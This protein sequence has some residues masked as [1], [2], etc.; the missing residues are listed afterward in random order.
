MDR[1]IVPV[2][3]DFGNKWLKLCIAING[4]LR[5]TNLPAAYA[6]QRPS[7][8]ILPSSGKEV[9]RLQ[10]FSLPVGDT[11]LW[12]GVDI[13][14]GP[15]FQK[16]DDTKYDPKHISILFKAGL[17]AWSQKHKVDLA[18]L[19]KLNVVASMPPGAFADGKSRK[20]A[21]AAYRKAFNRGKSHLQIDGAQVVTQF[22]GLQREAVG[23]IGS[24]VRAKTTT[25]IVDIGS[26]TVDYV[27]YN[28]GLSPIW[29]KSANVGLA[30]AY[31]DINPA[32]P[33]QAELDAFRNKKVLHP[34]IKL[35]F[36]D[37]E[38]RI[39]MIRRGMETTEPV[40]KIVFIG[41][42]AASMTL[43]IQLEFKKLAPSVVIKK[44]AEYQN[45]IENWRAAGGKED[46]N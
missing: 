40:E 28:G 14:G 44:A 23:V 46:A 2:G 38:Q 32:N 15:V 3:L 12:F 20:L 35:H 31:A 17:Y 22:G 13:L 42:G 4:K 5:L 30:H 33:N 37:I 43:P 36:S 18:S 7:R 9:N 11:V 39:V 16:L 25:L 8:Q 6:I 34:R 29:A 19:G 10:A 26:G 1:N 45:A 27:L 21:E 24:I 41:G